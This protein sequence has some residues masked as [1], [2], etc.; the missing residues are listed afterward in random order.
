M[1]KKTALQS[2]TNLCDVASNYIK[3]SE[4]ESSEKSQG[5][6][7]AGLSKNCSSR[8]LSNCKET[9]KRS[10]EKKDCKIVPQPVNEV[11]DTKQRNFEVHDAPDA[12]TTGVLTA[13][14]RYHQN[15]KGAISD[16]S[17][18]QLNICSRT[19]NRLKRVRSVDKFEN[20]DQPFKCSRAGQ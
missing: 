9:S 11:S 19:S 10:T 3:K 2:E 13:K 14:N 7:Q 15:T 6:K 20:A 5:R 17:S 1:G 8:K 12:V 16:K 4:S 18:Q